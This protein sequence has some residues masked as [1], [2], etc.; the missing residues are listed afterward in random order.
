MLLEEGTIVTTRGRH[1]VE[2]ERY[3]ARPGTELPLDIPIVVLVD[4]L[5]ASASEIVAAALQD[6]HRAVVAG[7]RSWGKGSVQNVIKLEGG[8]SAIRLTVGSYRR[9]SG[10]EIHKWKDAKETDDWGVR[11][12]DSLEV[13]LTNRQHELVVSARRKRDFLPWDEL[14]TVTDAAEAEDKGEAADNKPSVRETEI[15][16]AARRDPITID[17]QL[18]KAVEYLKDSGSPKPRPTEPQ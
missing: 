11:P 5:T 13:L 7:Q 8:K 15:A 9:P 17:P 18:R 4:R 1:D 10:K 12:N 14:T 6:N 3:V 16:A 2:L